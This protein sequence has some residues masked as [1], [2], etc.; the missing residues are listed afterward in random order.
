MKLYTT[1]KESLEAFVEDVTKN[2]KMFLLR[3]NHVESNNPSIELEFSFLLLLWGLTASGEAATTKIAIEAD[4]WSGKDVES[5]WY[6]IP[7]ATVLEALLLTAAPAKSTQSE[8]Q[9]LLDHLKIQ[10]YTFELLAYLFDATA[11]QLKN[12]LS[13]IKPLMVITQKLEKMPMTPNNQAILA[14]RY[15]KLTDV[16]SK[17]TRTLQAMVE[18]QRAAE[19]SH[20]LNIEVMSFYKLKIG[21][22]NC[23]YSFCKVFKRVSK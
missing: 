5:Y 22:W 10:Q 6:L 20:W 23:T 13:P 14:L 12:D 7:V 8:N 9:K 18:L 17:A 4:A 16:M 11:Q 2:K 21:L 15:Q 1:N 19:L 3:D